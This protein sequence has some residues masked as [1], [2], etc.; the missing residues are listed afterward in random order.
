MLEKIRAKWRQ[1]I[2]YIGVLPAAIWLAFRWPFIVVGLATI[3]VENFISKKF[4]MPPA[5][6]KFVGIGIFFALLAI[7]W[8]SLE[9]VVV[10]A[11]MA[12]TAD[13][14]LLSE[15]IRL[16]MQELVA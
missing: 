9:M 2:T 8:W 6:G 3:P 12:I 14:I 5:V 11:T 15:K 10:L 16:R 1:V 7:S 13:L 4:N